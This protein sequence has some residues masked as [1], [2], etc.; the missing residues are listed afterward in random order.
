[1]ITKIL[2]IIAILLAIPTYGISLIIWLFVKYK[3]DQF[4]A[5]RVL[6]NAIIMFYNKNGAD[7]FRYRINNAALPMVFNYFGG[8]ILYNEPGSIYG[9]LP[10]PLTGDLML[11]RMIQYSDNR[12]LIK[13]TK[14]SQAN[15]YYSI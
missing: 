2:T 1:L 11:V 6:I 10:N 7:E 5:N 12:L 13:A 4:C 3:Y 9:E 8:T 15:K 14:S